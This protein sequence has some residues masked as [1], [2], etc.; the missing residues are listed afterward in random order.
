[1][2]KLF[3]ERALLPEGWAGNVLIEIDADGRIASSSADASPETA[4]ERHAIAV[5][6]LANLHSHA[7]QRGMAGLAETAGP[8][9][10]SFWTWRQVMYRFLERLMPE[11][12]E[13][14]AAQLY[15]EMLETGFT[16]VGEFHYLHHAP[17]GTWYDD[18]AEMAGRIVAAAGRTGIGLTLMPV[19]YAQGGFGG[20]PVQAQQRRFVSTVESYARLHAGAAR[21][22]RELPHAVIGLA[23][24]SLRAVTPASLASI[25]DRFEGGPIH[26]HIAE[27][28]KEVEDCRA[29]SGTTPVAWLLANRPVD[30]RWCLVHATHMTEAETV[31]MANSGAVAGLCPQTEANLGDG[32]FSGPAFFAA[33]GRFGIGT[34][35]HIRVDAAEEMR[36]LEYSQRLRDRARNVL[37]VEGRSTGRALYEVACR[38]GAL[39]IGR[40]AGILAAGALA[41]IITLDAEHPLLVG[42]KDD[43]ILD[44]WLF[45][46]DRSL[47]R[48]V[49][50]A[51]RPVVRAGRHPARDAIARRF[52]LTM[53]RLAE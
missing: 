23:P 46:G 28:T 1:M 21:H 19:F 6:G 25:T 45:S 51:G 13:V 30:R 17:D 52:A 44:S 22:I 27:Q 39:A 14:V 12:V 50:V 36:T 9:R 41:D 47:V 20:E 2:S 33:A 53:R 32:I 18:P 11:D 43:T 7:F 8:T 4:D 24:H 26:I 15:V 37:A 40:G 42:R 16:S 5:P 49:W 29:W 31:A 3:F 35:S 48:D 10:D 34:D 38:D